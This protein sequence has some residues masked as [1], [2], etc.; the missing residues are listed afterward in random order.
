MATSGSRW[1]RA[2]SKIG[3]YM[4]NSGQPRARQRSRRSHSD[5]TTP[6]VTSSSTAACCSSPSISNPTAG[7]RPR[8]TIASSTVACPA[9]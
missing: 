3:Q 2:M 6:P 1:R 9:W 7:R 8:C 4:L 5:G